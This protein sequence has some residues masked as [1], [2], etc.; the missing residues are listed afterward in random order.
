MAKPNEKQIAILN[1]LSTQIE[2][3]KKTNDINSPTH[4]GDMEE[5]LWNLDDIL[6]ERD[7]NEIVDSLS[8]LLY[9]VRTIK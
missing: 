9:I 1:Y 5:E 4:N 3:W 8:D 7:K 6:D 2:Y